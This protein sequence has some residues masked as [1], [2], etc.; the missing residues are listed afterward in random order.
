[1]AGHNKWSQIKHK[2]AKLDA[3]RGK[4]FTKVIKEITVSAKEGG[5]DPATNA[6]LRQLVEKAKGVNMPLENITRAIKR[7]TGELPGVHYEACTYEG[8]GPHGIAVMVDT[9]SDNKNRTVADL[10]RLFT[11]GGGSLGESGSVAWMFKRMGV[12]RGSSNT[13]TEDK[14]MEA[15]IDFD[16]TDIR[17]DGVLFSVFCEPKS[18]DV[19]KKAVA[20]AGINVESAELEWVSHNPTPLDDAKSAKA[21]EFL[22]TLHDHDDVQNVYTTL[23]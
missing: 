20:A 1:M 6:Q 4:A 5:G 14:L 7:G 2:K 17:H 3:K 8:Y 22:S 19:V 18:L 16:I 11:K 23:A 9:L 21:V 15:L 13:M 10:R 12:I